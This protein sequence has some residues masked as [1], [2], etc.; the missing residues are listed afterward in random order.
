PPT[1]VNQNVVTTGAI[2]ATAK[3]NSR[4]VRPL[5][6]RLVNRAIIGPYPTNHAKKNTVQKPNHSSSPRKV[7]NETNSLTYKPSAPKK[8]LK[9]NIAGP[10]I[11]TPIIKPIAKIT[12]KLLKN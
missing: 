1:T 5:E 4:I 2:T 3:T 6:I 7:F 12:L 8:L 11:K 10:N 9:I